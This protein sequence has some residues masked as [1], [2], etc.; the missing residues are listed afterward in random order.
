[1]SHVGSAVKPNVRRLFRR[2]IEVMQT[3]WWEQLC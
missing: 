2:I 1:L 3:L